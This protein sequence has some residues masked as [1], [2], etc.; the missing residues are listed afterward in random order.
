MA[1]FGVRTWHCEFLR[2][3]VQLL[4]AMQALASFGGSIWYQ[5][6]RGLEVSLRRHGL[7][8]KGGYSLGGLREG[9]L[10]ALQ[11]R[12]VAQGKITKVLEVEGSDLP[13]EVLDAIEDLSIAVKV[14]PPRQNLDVAGTAKSV[15]EAS[16]S[17]PG[18]NV[19]Q[20]SAWPF[21]HCE[22]CDETFRFASPWWQ[23][24]EWRQKEVLE[25][26][27]PQVAARKFKLVSD[28]FIIASTLSFYN[29]TGP[30]WQTGGTSSH[31]DWSHALGDG[32]PGEYDKSAI[33]DDPGALVQVCAP[34]LTWVQYKPT[35]LICRLAMSM[36]ED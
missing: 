5:P 7:L 6:M 17:E 30:N 13:E 9:V 28:E 29:L 31:V 20:F 26:L 21:P 27:F 36:I 25:R 4:R 23:W 11:R 14:T 12:A 10:A 8:P 3:G 18:L 32:H 2:E 35:R 1:T 22:E 19:T 15:S 34:T 24:P 33:L 16:A